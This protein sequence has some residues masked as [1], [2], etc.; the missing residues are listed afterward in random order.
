MEYKILIVAFIFV[1]FGCQSEQNT[2]QFADQAPPEINVFFGD[3]YILTVGDTYY[4]YGTSSDTGIEAYKSEDL[5]NWEGPVGATGGFALHK[6]DVY[7]EQWFWAPEVYHIDGK[8]YMFFSVE[9][10]MAIATSDNP[11]GPF[12]QEDPSVL[13]DHK[14]IDH[15]LFVDE[16]GTKYIYFANFKDGLEIWGA[17]LEDDFS[18]IK[19][20]TLTKVLSQSQDWEKSK[21]KPVGTV[22]EGPYVLKKDGRYYMSYSANHYASQDYGIGWA[23]AGEP[24]GDWTKSD[25][26]PIIQ[27]PDSLV[28]TGHSAFFRDK[29]DKLHIVYHAHFDTTEVHPRKGYINEVELVKQEESDILIPQILSPKIIPKVQSEK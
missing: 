12:T 9:E 10:H 15:H 1:A 18:A 24:L 20:E 16:D 28:G 23:Y 5:Q 21:K 3:P 6:S 29:N 22:N 4:M 8:Y 11:E 17:E 13:R 25:E 14:S 7:G 19:E 27:N 26:N 2:S